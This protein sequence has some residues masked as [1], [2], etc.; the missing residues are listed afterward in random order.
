MSGIKSD[1]AIKLPISFILCAL[2]AFVTSL[3][4][5]LV[6]SQELLAGQFRFPEIWMGA[7]FLL[8]GFAV[9]IAMGA[10]YQLVPV[11]FLTPIWNQSFGF[12][13]FYVTVVGIIFLSIML[14]INPSLAIY[15]GILTV[16]GI[17]MFTFQMLK[18]LA[19]RKENTAMSHLVLAA[20]L[21]FLLTILAGLSLTWNFAFGGMANHSSILYSHIAFG[22]A[23]W[24]T[25]LIFGFSYKLV[26]MFSLSHGA[27][28]KRRSHPFICMF[29]A[30]CY[31]FFPFGSTSHSFNH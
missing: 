22:V 27:S 8:L 10:M 2:V 13:Q 17:L 6:N 9:M 1:T 12:V 3:F 15:G 23:G 25:L 20:I 16:I 11:A 29:S 30:Y 31:S 24:F 4:I 14:G 7:H 19:K 18:T 5:L 26:P 28:M 21:C